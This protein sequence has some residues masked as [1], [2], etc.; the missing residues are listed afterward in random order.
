MAAGCAILSMDNF[1]DGSRV[2]DSN[3][4]GKHLN[5][6][7]NTQHSYDALPTASMSGLNKLQH[8]DVVEMY[9]LQTPVL[10][11]MRDFDALA[12]Q[13]SSC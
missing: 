6:S 11:I 10:S 4:D 13:C 9:F 8:N 5:S 3:F 2:I 1:N 7:S 12:C